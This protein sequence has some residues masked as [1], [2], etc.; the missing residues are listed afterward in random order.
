MAAIPL[1][2]P[3]PAASSNQPGRRAWRAGLPSPRGKKRVAPIRFC[4]RWGLPC[5]PRCR[6]RG[7][8]LPHPFTLT[9]QAGRS[10][11]CGTVPGVA[12]AGGYPAPFLHGART[13]LPG[14]EGPER[15]PGRLIRSGDAPDAPAP[16]SA[17]VRRHAR[18]D[19]PEA[20]AAGG[21]GTRQARRTR[22]HADGE[23]LTPATTC[24]YSPSRPRA[25]AAASPRPSAGSRWRSRPATSRRPCSRRAGAG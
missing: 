25:P 11:F 22:P 3:L 14:P 19:R 1:G 5:R 21:D 18:G 15:P 13:F 7:A 9:L 20:R 8:L 12:P 23:R 16:S 6:V 24:R 4:S 10:A 2:R 17:P